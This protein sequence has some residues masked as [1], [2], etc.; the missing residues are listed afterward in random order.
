MPPGNSSKSRTSG[1]LRQFDLDIDGQL[2]AHTD[3]LGQTTRIDAIS[4][5]G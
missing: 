2:L 5:A 1:R 4:S 3:A